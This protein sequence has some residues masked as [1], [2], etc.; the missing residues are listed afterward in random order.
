MDTSKVQHTRQLHTRTPSLLSLELCTCSWCRGQ[1]TRSLPHRAQFQCWD[2]HRASNL[3]R[4]ELALKKLNNITSFKYSSSC[5]ITF[6][7][8]LSHYSGHRT[9]NLVMSNSFQNKKREMFGNTR[10]NQQEGQHS[11]GRVTASSGQSSG[12]AHDITAHISVRTPSWPA[13]QSQ[14]VQGSGDHLPPS[15][16]CSPP[17]KH[18]FLM[19]G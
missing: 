9:T 12:K 8:I 4:G 17:Q 18:F 13:T 6:S 2:L 5:I 16:Y 1:V 3:R 7:L 11:P 10:K 19:P 14:W 15:L